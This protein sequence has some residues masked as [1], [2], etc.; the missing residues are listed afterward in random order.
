MVKLI[1]V[2]IG[3]LLE[4]VLMNQIKGPDLAQKVY[5]KGQVFLIKLIAIPIYFHLYSLVITCLAKE[6]SQIRVTGVEPNRAVVWDQTILILQ[7]NCLSFVYINFIIDS[8]YK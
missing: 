6:K 3:L 7:I 1:I 8:V 2:A 4:S 5:S